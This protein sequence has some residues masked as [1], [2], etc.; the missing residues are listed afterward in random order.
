[1]FDVGFTELVLLGIIALIVLG[2]ERL[3]K[4][5][6]IFGGFLRRARR[7][8]ES[9]KQEIE[10]EIDADELKRQM[11]QIPTPQALAQEISRP[12]AEVNAAIVDEANRLQQALSS[13]EAGPNAAKPYDH[14]ADV[15]YQR[16]NAEPPES[17]EP[18]A[19]ALA[20]GLA[21]APLAAPEPAAPAALVAPEPAATAEKA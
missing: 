3:P 18:A 6:R 12:F 17:S 4:A 21:P 13:T 15:D 8:F 1:M 10:R 7:S 5:A 16:H 14:D 2:P 9:I 20:Q 19:N 11:A